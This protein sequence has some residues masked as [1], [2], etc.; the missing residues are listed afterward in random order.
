MYPKLKIVTYYNEVA[1]LSFLNIKNSP[2]EFKV[3]LCT[4][5]STETEIPVTDP[6]LTI[7]NHGS[8]ATYTVAAS[9]RWLYPLGVGTFTVDA[10][11]ITAD[12]THLEVNEQFL[13][14]Q[15]AEYPK[16]QI[17][18]FKN[19]VRQPSFLDIANTSY[20]FKVALYFSEDSFTY[21]AAS[22][23]NLHVNVFDRN[24]FARVESN[25]YKLYM[26]AIG[27]CQI[28]AYYSYAGQ[29]LVVKQEILIYEGFLR[30][31]F[32]LAGLT[33]FDY[34]IY[35]KNTRFQILL[36][37]M[38]ELF[39]ILYAYQADIQGINDHS[40]IKDKFLNI[41][42]RSFGFEKKAM[43]DGTK[44]EY[45]Y[46]K[47]YREL[48]VNLMDLIKARGTK[49]AYELFFGAMG[50]DIEMLEHWFDADGNLIEI[51]PDDLENST[52]FAYT[53]DGTPVDNIQVPHIDPRKDVSPGNKYNYCQK[54]VYVRPIISL[55]AD[56][57]S[58]PSSEHAD[59]ERVLMLQYLEWL[60][61]NHIEYLQ[62]MF[63]ISLI[64]TEID[65]TTYPGEFLTTTV[66]EAPE[67][68]LRDE[69]TSFYV[70]NYIALC[71]F[72]LNEADVFTTMTPLS[73][74]PVNPGIP[75]WVMPVGDPTNLDHDYEGP[76]H[77]TSLSATNF[78]DNRGLLIEHLRPMTDAV[79]FGGFVELQ[80]FLEQPLKYDTIYEYDDAEADSIGIRYDRG[81]IFNEN[82]LQV[83]NIE[84]VGDL[85]SSY[86]QT[87]TIADTLAYLATTYSITA[88]MAQRIVNIYLAM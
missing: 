47:M 5:P 20:D 62:T 10:V 73:V 63:K 38:F 27:T 24:A 31:N 85:Y 86:L 81:V 48:L 75:Y 56:L 76:W 74:T 67:Y 13:I 52:F 83:L 25:V 19:D 71:G 51:N 39:D 36:K 65:G 78:G 40:Q 3:F 7:S 41:V 72:Y 43:Y 58:H 82:D 37:T 17:H 53:T 44:W 33:T 50:Y 45:A 9:K 61:P 34:N 84:N 12:G 55:K 28:G 21:L 1:Q 6:N 2:Y 35:Q 42:G 77:G 54:S 16:L 64:S 49:L 22:N 79:V 68:I 26:L 11:F 60:K 80:D 69:I 87:H 32:A 18:Y 15:E 30:D 14:F 46:N 8:I 23:V 59:Y 4:N 88:A 70:A 66:G 57:L 29:D